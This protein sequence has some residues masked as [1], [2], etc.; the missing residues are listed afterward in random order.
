VIEHE[1]R[2]SPAVGGRSVFGHEKPIGPRQQ[3]LFD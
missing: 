3:R 1:H 2:I